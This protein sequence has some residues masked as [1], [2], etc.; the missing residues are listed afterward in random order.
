[1]VYCFPLNNGIVLIGFGEGLWGIVFDSFHALLD[2][3]LIVLT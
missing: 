3:M 1:M 2:I